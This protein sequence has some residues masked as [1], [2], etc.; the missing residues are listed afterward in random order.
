[1]KL[2]YCLSPKWVIFMFRGEGRED[3]YVWQKWPE[4]YAYL[5]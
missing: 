5:T 1:M 4:I 3:I 2:N